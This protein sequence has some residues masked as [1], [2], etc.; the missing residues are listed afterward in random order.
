MIIYCSG[1]NCFFNASLCFLSERCILAVVPKRMNDIHILIVTTLQT[2]RQDIMYF[3]K[4]TIR[5]KIIR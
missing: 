4:N 1:I 2:R 3:T 5:A